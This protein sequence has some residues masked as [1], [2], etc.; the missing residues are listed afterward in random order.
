MFLQ[1]LQF[2]YQKLKSCTDIYSDILNLDLWEES[3]SKLSKHSQTQQ[4]RVLQNTARFKCVCC[5][6]MHIKT[7]MPKIPP[8]TVRTLFK[9]KILLML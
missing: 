4:W 3:Q 9:E 5:K 7:L 6:K 2:T 8:Q 1:V